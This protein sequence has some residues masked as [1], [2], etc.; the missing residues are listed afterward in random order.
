VLGDGA[1]V[2]APR[3]QIVLLK[4]GGPHRARDL[5]FRHGTV[6]ELLAQQR[7]GAF[8]AVVRV[9]ARRIWRTAASAKR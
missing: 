3:Q 7:P 1:H 4:V 6:A 2:V 9:F 5:S 8:A